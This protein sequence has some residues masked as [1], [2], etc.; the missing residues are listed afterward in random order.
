MKTIR[1]AGSMIYPLLGVEPAEEN[2]DKE[3]EECCFE[4]HDLSFSFLMNVST[5]F[6]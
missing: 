4:D 6:S 1:I 3:E 5:W 2:E